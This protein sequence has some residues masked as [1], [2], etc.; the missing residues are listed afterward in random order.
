MYARTYRLIVNPVSK[1]FAISRFP[2]FYRNHVI[3]VNIVVLVA[4]FSVV[5]NQNSGFSVSRYSAK[6]D[7]GL[8]SLANFQ[9]AHG[10]VANDA[11][12]NDALSHLMQKNPSPFASMYFASPNRGHGGF[13]MDVNTN[14]G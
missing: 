2:Y 12:F 9:A 7:D 13:A 5:V 14:Q 8:G 1:K 11:V 6:F 10:V 3:F 4:A